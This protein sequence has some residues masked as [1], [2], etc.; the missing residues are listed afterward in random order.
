MFHRSAVVVSAGL[1]AFGL[2]SVSHVNA[3]TLLYSNF[4]TG[5]STV[6]SD[7]AY[8]VTGPTS[9]SGEADHAVKFTVPG[10]VDYLPEAI[11]YYA[12]GGAA[13]VVTWEISPDNSGVPDSSWIWAGEVSSTA[14]N[15]WSEWETAHAGAV[16]PLC[17][18]DSYWLKAIAQDSATISWGS[19]TGSTEAVCAAFSPGAW[20]PEPGYPGS[21]GAPSIAIWGSPVPEP[22]AL[23]LLG[24][25]VFSLLAYAGRQIMR[26]GRSAP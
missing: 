21:F 25:G 14:S 16:V 7:A 4:D 1:V 9:Q 6:I 5:S 15:E 2:T 26:F 22:S 23:V 8:A 12:H 18:G 20:Q 13:G 17:H 10:S 3:L 19:S 24:I 11:S